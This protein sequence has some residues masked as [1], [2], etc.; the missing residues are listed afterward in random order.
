M[1]AGKR[2]R[3][4]FGPFGEQQMVFVMFAHILS[5][6]LGRLALFAHPLGWLVREASALLA[7]RVGDSCAGAEP[8]RA[9][10]DGSFKREEGKYGHPQTDQRGGGG[11]KLV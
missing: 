8:C 1:I 4:P 2:A 6:R 7:G 9:W 10:G 5:S 3:N 11:G